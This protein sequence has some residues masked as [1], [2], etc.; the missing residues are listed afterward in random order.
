MVRF[1]SIIL[2]VQIF[3]TIDSCKIAE[4]LGEA[5]GAGIGEATALLGCGE[6]GIANARVLGDEC[7]VARH[8]HLSFAQG[9]DGELAATALASLLKPHEL[10]VI[11]HHH[12]GLYL[13]GMIAWLVE[14]FL[15]RRHL[16][17][18][19]GGDETPTPIPSRGEGGL[20]SFRGFIRK[21][22]QTPLPSGGVGGGYILSLIHI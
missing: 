1:L 19:G 3:L 18:F 13:V 2:F 8:P 7:P 4:E 17:P 9:G 21:G 14:V 12:R 11:V 5:V 15:G 20:I 16:E 6:S 10:G 22:I